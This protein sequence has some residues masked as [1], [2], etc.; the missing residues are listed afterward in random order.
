MGGVR[1]THTPLTIDSPGVGPSM[2]SSE[3]LPE[4]KPRRRW[5]PDL[6]DLRL[7]CATCPNAQMIT[8]EDAAKSFGVSTPTLGRWIAEH[9]KE[10]EAGAGNDT[11]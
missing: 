11:P 5:P 8:F 10:L 3:L 9:C 1:I 6:S 2:D 7:I 4:K